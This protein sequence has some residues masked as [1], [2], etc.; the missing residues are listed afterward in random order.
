MKPGTDNHLGNTN[1]NHDIFTR[2]CKIGHYLS[3]QL[4][5]V[6]KK[7]SWCGHGEMGTL[8]HC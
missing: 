5:H 8:V 1:Y 6:K 7:I 3:P 2:V 4:P